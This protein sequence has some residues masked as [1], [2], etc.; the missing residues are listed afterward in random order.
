MLSRGAGAS[1][2]PVLMTRPLGWVPQQLFSRAVCLHCQQPRD[3]R[4]Q[5]GLGLE[6]P[7]ECA[8]ATRCCSAS[9]TWHQV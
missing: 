9:R 3:I 1:L 7:S 5:P 4:K 6:V 8:E 2:L